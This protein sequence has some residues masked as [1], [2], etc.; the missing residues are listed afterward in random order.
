MSKSSMQSLGLLVIAAFVMVVVSTARAQMPHQRLP[1]NPSE[2]PE[3]AVSSGAHRCSISTLAG[4]WVFITDLA[5]TQQGTLDRAALGTLNIGPNGTLQGKYD[6]EGLDGFHP[7]NSYVGTVSVN[8]DCSGTMSQQDVGS[9]VVVLHSMVI[10]RDGR[11]IWG[12]L[13]DPAIDVGTFRAKRIGVRRCSNATIAGAWV[14][15]TDLLYLPPGTVDG[16]AL[17]TIN[18]RKDGSSDQMFDF[19]G[20]SGFF[21]GIPAVG[22]VSV[23]PDCTGTLSFHVVGDPQVVVQSFVVANSGRE[24]WGMFQDPAIDVGTYRAKRINERD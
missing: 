11:E 3:V 20:T 15:T 6:W 18:Y 23:N 9:D 7:G 1:R 10:A 5:H 17:G 16:Y 13:Q 22:T 24:I 8:P 19:E 12:V 2:T 4:A 14:F 21:P